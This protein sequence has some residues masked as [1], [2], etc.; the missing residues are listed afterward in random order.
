MK[1]DTVYHAMES[2]RSA[3]CKLKELSPGL[4]ACFFSFYFFYKIR[5]VRYDERPIYKGR[6]FTYSYII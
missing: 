4:V 2:K 3:F 5:R 1:L 6:D